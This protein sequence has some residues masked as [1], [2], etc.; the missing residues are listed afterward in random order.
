MW[1]LPA[2]N[3]PLGARLLFSVR[4]PRSASSARDKQVCES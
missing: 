2:W 1:D 4:L 3:V